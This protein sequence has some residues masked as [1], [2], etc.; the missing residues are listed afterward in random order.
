MTVDLTGYDPV[1]LAAAARS[2]LACPA[3]VQ[4][5]VDGVADVGDDLGM[6]DLEGTPTF[7]CV[8]DNE[9]ARAAE[10]RASALLTVASGLG[11]PG[12]PE[13]DVTLTLAGTLRTRTREDCAC[14]GET[15]AIVTLDLT[16]ALLAH[17]RDG[18]AEQQCRVPLEHFCSPAHTL[19]PGYLQRWVE[20]ANE[21]HQEELRRAVATTS[22]TRLSQV[23]GVS[24]AGLR[25][26][27]VE[28]QWV[29][30]DGAHTTAL[31]FAHPATSTEEL[32]ELLRRE[33][34]AGLC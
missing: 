29:D 1:T 6:Q 14:C 19:N 15:R 34:H 5:V 8:P 16:F 33:L 9:L 13:R 21:C 30:L 25:P 17:P 4:L 3:S 27:R 23:V 18:R 2:V 22:R 11:R 24:L 26:D 7:S 10:R 20:H 12:S 28:V 31:T 32:G